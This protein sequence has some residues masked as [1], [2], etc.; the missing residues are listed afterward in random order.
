MSGFVPEFPATIVLPRLTVPLAAKMAPAEDAELRVKV[1]LR[2]V[3]VAPTVLHS[4]PPPPLPPVPAVLPEIV[5]LAMY[6]GFSL[7]IPPQ[8]LPLVLPLMV[9][10]IMR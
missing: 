8:S 6:N 2:M 5:L 9:E 1:E 7:R 3:V 10:L 4:P